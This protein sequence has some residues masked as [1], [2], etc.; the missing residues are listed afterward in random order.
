[1]DHLGEK[2]EKRVT[3]LFQE[4]KRIT[5]VPPPY[6]KTR[7]LAELMERR[8]RARGLFFWRLTAAA[9]TAMALVAVVWLT[10]AQNVIFMAVTGRPF[11]VKI[12]MEDLDTYRIAQA[13]IVLPEG[14]HFYSETIPELHDRRSLVVAWDRETTNGKLP[15]VIRTDQ[16]GSKKVLVRFFDQ[17]RAVVAERKLEINFVA[18]TARR[19]G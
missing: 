10:L 4:V 6:L 13:E 1:M 11:V 12:E 16:E 9:S 2:S 8:Q 3:Q 7:A 5:F 18:P 17:N 19:E 15:F 14:L